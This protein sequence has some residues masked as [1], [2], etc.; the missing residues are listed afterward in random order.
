M[1]NRNLRHGEVTLGR[2]TKGCPNIVHPTSCAAQITSVSNDIACSK[3]HFCFC[4]VGFVTLSYKRIMKTPEILLCSSYCS[5]WSNAMEHNFLTN[6]KSLDNTRVLK[7]IIFTLKWSFRWS[8]MSFSC[9]ICFSCQNLSTPTNMLSWLFL[10]S[11]L[12]PV[13]SMV[14]SPVCLLYTALPSITSENCL[15]LFLFQWLYV[16]ELE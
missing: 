2:L 8:V 7:E 12:K 4:H 3:L 14:E 1:W 5:P 16:P 13:K 9:R 10:C 11:T 15:C 6:D